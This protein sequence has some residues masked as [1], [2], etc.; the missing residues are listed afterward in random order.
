MPSPRNEFS[1]RAKGAYKVYCKYLGEKI[2]DDLCVGPLKF[3]FY[4][5]LRL[6]KDLHYGHFCEQRNAI[7]FLASL[8]LKKVSSMLHLPF[9]AVE[10]LIYSPDDYLGDM[11]YDHEEGLVDDLFI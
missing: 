1:I 3:K 9:R 11:E 10:K 4:T 5:I 2:D 6:T 7:E 8:D